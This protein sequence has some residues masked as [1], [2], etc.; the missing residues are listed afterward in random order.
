L[1][2]S[3]TLLRSSVGSNRWSQNAW[4]GSWG[5]P[6]KSKEN[7]RTLYTQRRM[8]V[9]KGYAIDEGGSLPLTSESVEEMAGSRTGT[10]MNWAFH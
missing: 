9:V 10:G 4:E 5:N 6:T 7:S 8:G 1:P 2:T 3:G